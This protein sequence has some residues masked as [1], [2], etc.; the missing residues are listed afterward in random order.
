MRS[1]NAGHGSAQ[2]GAL[3]RG[4]LLPLALVHQDRAAANGQTVTPPPAAAS[5]LRLAI[6]GGS[7]NLCGALWF[8]AVR[9]RVAVIRP[10]LQ[11]LAALL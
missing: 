3:W 10:H 5:L 2:S 9:Q 1:G 6:L 7:G 4:C 8:H 11:H